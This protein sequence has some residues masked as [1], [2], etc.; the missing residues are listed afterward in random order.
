MS[1]YDDRSTMTSFHWFAVCAK[2]LPVTA[3][4]GPPVDEE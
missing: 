2:G 4:H 3:D 1:V